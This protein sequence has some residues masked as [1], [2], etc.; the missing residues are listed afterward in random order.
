MKT[1]ARLRWLLVFVVFALL[2]AACSNSDSSDDTSGDTSAAET[3]TTVAAKDPIRVPAINQ[4]DGVIAWP[5]EGQAV[6]AI[7]DWYNAQG[8]LDG[9][10]LQLDVCTAGDDPES[11]QSCAQAIAN[12]DS[13]PFVHSIMVPN[14]ATLFDV[15]SNAG[16]P[17][18]AH[19]QFDIPDSLQPDVYASDPGLLPMATTLMLYT[20][21]DLGLRNIG[22]VVSDDEVGRGTAEFLSFLVEEYGGTPATIT[23]DSSVADLLP[24][25]AAADLDAIDGIIFVPTSVE[26]CGPA[27]QALKSLGFDKPILGGDACTAQTFVDSGNVEGWIFVVGTTLLIEGDAGRDQ[28]IGIFNEYN[29][30]PIGGLVAPASMGTY[31]VI[32]V[33]EATYA[34]A[35]GDIAAITSDVIRQAALDYKGPFTLGPEVFSCPGVDPFVGLCNSSATVVQLEGDKF[36][37]LTD[38]YLVDVA[39]YAAL[40]EG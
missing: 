1:I 25:F 4:E 40:L 21:E 32:G 22:I 9:H 8:G 27:S 28:T 23:Y 10:P 37:Q 12:D 17:I 6:K 34:A 35:G 15:M 29:G 39:P 3:T 33:L 38:W 31:Y 11:T 30:P 19:N 18:L 16:K 7:F 20:L 36:N 2:M 5:D 24:V 26:D 14:S 13:A